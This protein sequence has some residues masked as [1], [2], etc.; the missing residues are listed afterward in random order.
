MI[1]R[2]PRAASTTTPVRRQLARSRRAMILLGLSVSNALSAAPL[3]HKQLVGIN[4]A[5][6]E[7]NEHAIPGVLGRD[8]NYPSPRDIDFF[9]NRGMTA[10]RLPFLWERLQ[11]DLKVGLDAREAARLDAVVRYITSHGGYV[12]LDPHNYARFRGHVIGGDDV[13][14]A[15]FA[16]FWGMLATRYGS[17]RRAVFGLMNEPHDIAPVLWRNAA[18]AAL[19]S[20]RDAGAANL[21]LVPG[22]AWSNGWNWQ[23]PQEGQSNAD[24]LERFSDAE[25][26]MAFE[27]H[28]YL[29]SDSSGHSATCVSAD[30]GVDRLRG[31][32]LWLREKGRRGFL[33]EFAGGASPRC[34]EALDRMLAFVKANED[35]WIGWTYWAAGSRWGDYIYSVQPSPSRKTPPQLDV[36]LRHLPTTGEPTGAAQKDRENA[37]VR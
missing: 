26:N 5:G 37:I 35:V 27:I 28:Q 8:Y 21:V 12:V 14:V 1:C 23:L 17:N 2:S 7:F 6:A 9:L 30:I 33:G 34:L 13:P 15:A 18:A 4:L 11:P 36:L 16:R 20:I 10:I 24:V 29:D 3:G 22:T 31:V 25:N 19:K 32:T